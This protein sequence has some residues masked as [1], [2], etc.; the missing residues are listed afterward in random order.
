MPIMG[1]ENPEKKL[2]FDVLENGESLKVW[3]QWTVEQEHLRKMNS[4]GMQGELGSR[5]GL[6]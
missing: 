2:R 6:A 4:L 1:L 5:G 3:D